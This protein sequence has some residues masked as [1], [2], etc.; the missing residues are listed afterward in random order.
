MVLPALR[1]CS[2]SE[3]KNVAAIMFHRTYHAL[4][5]GD[6]LLHVHHPLNG[7]RAVHQPDAGVGGV[8]VD[9]GVGEGSVFVAAGLHDSVVHLIE[10]TNYRQLF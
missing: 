1:A 4:D 3:A 10:E 9:A 5:K 2:P 8:S 6:P 7:H